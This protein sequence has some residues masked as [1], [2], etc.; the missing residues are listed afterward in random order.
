MSEW[1]K[2]ENGQYPRKG[3]IIVVKG[4]G[5]PEIYPHLLKVVDSLSF[6]LY[7]DPS[8]KLSFHNLTH[9]KLIESPY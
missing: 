4:Y 2:F 7:A 3:E 1:I 8:T 9:W 5:Q 6:Y